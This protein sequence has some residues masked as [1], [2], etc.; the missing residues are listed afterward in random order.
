MP[1]DE[2]YLPVANVISEACWLPWAHRRE[3]FKALFIPSLA[4]LALQMS[5]SGQ[6]VPPAAGWMVFL[7]QVLLWTLFAVACHRLVLLGLQ[8]P[9]VPVVPAWGWRESRFLG[10]MLVI[11]AV[12]WGATWM[13]LMTAGIVALNISETTFAATQRYLQWLVGIY[14]FAR[15]GPVLPAAAIGA[16]IDFRETWRKTRGG[17]TWRL[18]VI[19]G[20]LPWIFGAISEPLSGDDPGV[21]RQVAAFAVATV[22]LAVEIC[23]LSVSYRRLNARR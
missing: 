19:V 17:N 1:P 15:I 4:I 9:E 10:C 7:V 5:L 2:P 8:W 6:T 13:I 20:V 12:T 16:R 3:F 14:F 21:V 11:T 18:M 23:A 22:F